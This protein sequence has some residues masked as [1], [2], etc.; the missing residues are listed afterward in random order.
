[1][2]P[3]GHGSALQKDPKKTQLISK[4]IDERESY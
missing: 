3:E 4:A 1:M 2:D